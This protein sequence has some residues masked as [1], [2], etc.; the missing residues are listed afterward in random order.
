[1]KQQLG[2][3]TSVKFRSKTMRKHRKIQKM[4][5]LN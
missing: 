1:V 3:E 2:S 5:E 4:D